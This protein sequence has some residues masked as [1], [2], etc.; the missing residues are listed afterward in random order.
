M[1]LDEA[2]I[3]AAKAHK[4]MRRKGNNQ[5]YFFHPLEVLSLVSMMSDDEDI[6]C[7]AILHDT[8]EDTPVTIEDIKNK[9]GERVAKLVNYES[10]DKRGQINKSGTWI[11]R[12][13]EAINTLSSVNDIGAKMIALGDKV[14]NLRSMHLLQLQV[15]DEVWNY[16]NMKDPLK[17]YW[18]YSEVAKVL[19]DLK[20]YSV[21][22]EY[23]F[24][25]DSIFLKYVK[26]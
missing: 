19:D 4:G 26:E 2:I 16:F 24:L 21:Y 23:L 3:F 25:I 14:S 12:K 20:D 9:F 17:H 8:V 7:A 1:K 18:Y 22:K 10:E 11:D 15:G 6:L 13:Q 5:P